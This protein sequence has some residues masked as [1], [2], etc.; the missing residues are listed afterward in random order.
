MVVCGMECEQCIYYISDGNGKKCLNDI[1]QSVIINAEDNNPIQDAR[2]TI[3]LEAFRTV[4]VPNFIKEE[5]PAY[6]ETSAGASPSSTLP[7]GV[8]RFVDME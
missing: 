6:A 7:V 1:M 3:N 5:K 2:Y 8:R 4:A